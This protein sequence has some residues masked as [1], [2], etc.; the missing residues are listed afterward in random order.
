M[1]HRD[2]KPSNIIPTEN[3]VPMLFVFGISKLLDRNEEYTLTSTGIGVGTLEYM[4]PE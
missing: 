2:V 1:L 3:G 4:T